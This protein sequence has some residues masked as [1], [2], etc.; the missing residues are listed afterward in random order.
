MKKRKTFMI[1]SFI[2]STLLLAVGYAM[3]S[4][5]PLSI[6]GT[7]SA[8]AS[9][10]NFDVQMVAGSIN[11][12]GTTNNVTVIDNTSIS[13][14]QLNVSFAA[15][16]FTAKGDTAVV[17]YTIKNN[18]INLNALLS[19][20]GVSVTVPE[21]NDGVVYY[22]DGASL[23][24]VDYYF[25][26]SQSNKTIVINDDESSNSTTITIV[27]MLNKTILNEE[28]VLVNISLPINA[29]AQ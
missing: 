12:A 8:G 10:E 27:I 4:D 16:G 18:S 7:A 15:S 19:S 24:D 1:L 26:G 28:N 11:T 3:V 22:V 25:D 20:S 2:V 6:N 13:D 23:F 14:K 29:K 9:N 5:I 21:S 17:T